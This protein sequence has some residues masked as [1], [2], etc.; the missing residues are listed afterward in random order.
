MNELQKEINYRIIRHLEQIAAAGTVTWDR[1]PPP[2]VQWYFHKESLYDAL[3]QC[4]NLIYAAT[5]RRGGNRLVA[6]I[7]VCNVLETLTK[8]KASGGGLAAGDAGIVKIGEIGDLTVYKDPTMVTGRWLM[9]YK[10][11]NWLDTGYIHA[12]FLGLYVTPP[13]TLDDMITRKAMMQRSGQKIV[14]A[15]MYATG[16]ITQTGGAFGNP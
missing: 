14:N 2:N 1:T 15:F 12:P 3:I 6:G 13:I 5:Q 9:C 16:S 7:G 8:F 4:S 10:G 11:T